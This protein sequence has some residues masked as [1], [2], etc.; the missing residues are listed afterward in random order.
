MSEENHNHI[1]RK[2]NV[3]PVSKSFK[4]YLKRYGREIQLP[5]SYESLRHFQGAMPCYNKNG[6]DTLWETVFY[7]QSLT[8]EIHHALI[9]I[10]SFIK[11]E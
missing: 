8:R 1:S 10:Y 9:R 3:Y 4:K 5:I 11:A 2:K 7:H 6:E